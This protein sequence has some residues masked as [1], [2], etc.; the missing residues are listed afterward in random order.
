MPS[1]KILYAVLFVLFCAGNSA[2]ADGTTLVV[3]PDSLFFR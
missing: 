1:R 2:L 3:N